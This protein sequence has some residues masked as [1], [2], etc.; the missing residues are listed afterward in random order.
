MKTCVN[1]KAEKNLTNIKK[2]PE[3]EKSKTTGAYTL[4]PSD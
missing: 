3:L 2:M 4:C 1:W